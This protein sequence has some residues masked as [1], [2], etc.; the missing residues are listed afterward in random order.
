MRYFLW[1]SLL[2]SLLNSTTQIPKDP[3][4]PNIIFIL[5]DDLGWSSLSEQMD[6]AMPGSKSDYH[7]TPNIDRLLKSGM[8]FTQGYAPASI[9]SPTRRS[10]LFGHTPMRQDDESFGSRYEPGKNSFL[11][12][13]QVL[14]KINPEYVTAHFGKWDLR[15]GIPPASFGYDFSDGDNGNGQGNTINTKDEK[16]TTF[17]TEDNPKQIDTL[18]NR[19]KRFISD[20]VNQNKPF[21]LQLSHYATHA[22]ITARAETIARFEK[23]PKGD[24]HHH[25]AWAAMLADLDAS[26]SELISHLDQLGIRKNTYLFFMSD[27]G[28]VEFI[29]PVKNRLDHPDSF[30]SP[31]RNAPLRGGKWTLFE[32]GIRVPFFVSG[33]DIPVNSSSNT[34]V[35]GYDLLSTFADIAGSKEPNS[36][37]LDGNSFKA[38]LSNP[39]AN[40]TNRNLYFH[41][42]NN[43]YP[44]SAIRSGNYKLLKFW[45]TG[46]I[47]LFNLNK[48]PGEKTNLAAIEP[49]KRI[50]LNKELDRYFKEVNPALFNQLSTLT[51]K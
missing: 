1:F 3:I 15:I 27:N 32:G 5:A 19:T 49:E 44:H 46:E 47:L 35:T 29:A 8:R 23:I 24:K 40:T 25:A 21:F 18:T 30:P 39:K 14:K 11:T 12:I 10:I 37:S 34:L 13:P 20:Q 36:F 22:N 33:P 42:F 50:T 38:S 6:P 31:M 7:L 51:A 28:G 4:S 48:D 45:K 9:C 41:R 16:W 2:F 43:G 26:I 17:F